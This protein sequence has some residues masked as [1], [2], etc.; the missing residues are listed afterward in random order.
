MGAAHKLNMFD[1]EGDGA[2]APPPMRSDRVTV[3]QILEW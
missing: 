2:G 1:P 3:A